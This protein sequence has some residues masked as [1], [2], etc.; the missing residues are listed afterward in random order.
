[1]TCPSLTSLG[2]ITKLTE[3]VLQVGNAVMSEVCTE[4]WRT[5]SDFANEQP[6]RVNKWDKGARGHSVPGFI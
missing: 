4:Q 5:G 2:M 1:M 6:K 3:R